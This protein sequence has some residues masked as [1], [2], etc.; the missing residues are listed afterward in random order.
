VKEAGGDANP[1]IN[2][3]LVNYQDETYLVK[4][5]DNWPREFGISSLFE[6]VDFD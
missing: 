2:K 5:T 1:E 6:K 4:E 3:L